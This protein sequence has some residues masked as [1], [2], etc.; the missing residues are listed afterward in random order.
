MRGRNGGA[1]PLPLSPTNPA[2]RTATG[3]IERCL[4][5]DTEAFRPLVLRHQRAAFSVALHMLGSRADAEDVVQHGFTEA[6][7]AL[8]RF[9]GDG[10]ERAF[11]NWL[12]RI[13][14]NR[15]KDLLKS[16]RRTE[17]P[18]EREVQ[19]SEAAFAH[20]PTNPEAHLSNQEQRLRLESALL[21]VA[22]KYREV[23]ILKDIEELSY[24]E[25]RSILRLPITTLK[26]RVVRARAMLR[27]R[28]ASTGGQP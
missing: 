25:M 14:V 21:T 13:V 20:D 23:L 2:G 16:K 24:E 3:L 22:P 11:F 18:L 17:L 15:S 12:I 8:F 10:R 19:G 6:F 1:S 28:L 27:E 5:G 9:A 7:N 4:A 26:I